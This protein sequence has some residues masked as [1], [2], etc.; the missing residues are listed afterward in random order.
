M[1]IRLKVFVKQSNK[2][3]MS[4]L[5]QAVNVLG[6]LFTSNRGL[7]KQT[8][9]WPL[10]LFLK[11][12][13]DERVTACVKCGAYEGETEFKLARSVEGDWMTEYQCLRG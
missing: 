8:I 11:Y 4:C 10:W 7:V 13:K 5:A 2:L 12:M 3:G 6:P 9:W 1:G